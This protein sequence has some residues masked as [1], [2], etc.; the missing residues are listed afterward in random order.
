MAGL[1]V[2]TIWSPRRASSARIG[3]A[4]TPPARPGRTAAATVRLLTARSPE[5][6]MMPAP[7]GG[8]CGS[9]VFPMARQITAPA[10]EGECARRPETN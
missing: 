9:C 10:P 5:P 8:V 7:T 3:R 6:G 2:S 1:S 4:V